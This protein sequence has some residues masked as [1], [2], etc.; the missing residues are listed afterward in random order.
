MSISLICPKCQSILAADLFESN[1]EKM[2]LRCEYCGA[3]YL[4][5]DGC[6]DLVIKKSFER[7]F[8]EKRYGRDPSLNK[9]NLDFEE[10]KQRWL[11]P[12]VPARKIILNALD[13]NHLG[14][15]NILLLGN[16]QSAKE[17]YFLK[18]GAKV[19]CSDISLAAILDVKNRFVLGNYE[20]KIVFLGVDAYN[21]PL[22]NESVDV[23]FGD[24][25]V[26]HLDEIDL[27]FKE[28]H[29]VLKKGGICLFRDTAYSKI[30]QN[31]K[32]SIL[33]PLLRFSHK[34]WGISPEDLRATHRGG[35]SEREIKGIRSK[36]NF[37]DMIFIRFGF[38]V[39]IIPR[40]LGKIFGYGQIV[41]RL[42]R[43]VFPVLSD[44]D[45]YLAKRWNVYYKNT[46]HLVWGF[47]K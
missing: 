7:D 33:R 16:G 41:D 38:L 5:F 26:H 34:K 14:G 28:V 18:Y 20:D 22:N 12:T 6:I 40:G 8:Y 13:V 19:I 11:D 15:K 43:K 37:S 39:T 1:I 35:Y 32:F 46:L 42:K 27:F 44:V 4:N 3:E 24:G 30:W 9:E 36:H 10:L 29:R 21:I 25:F 2:N 31:L 23:I 45:N 47:R 17:L